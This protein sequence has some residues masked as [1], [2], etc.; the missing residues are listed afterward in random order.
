MKDTKIFLEN[1]GGKNSV[2]NSGGLNVSLK[3]NRKLIPFNDMGEVISSLDVYNDE[4]RECNKIRLTCQVNPICSNVLFNQISEIVKYEG[5]EDV[6]FVNYAINGERRDPFGENQVVY[7]SEEM[8]FW[9]SDSMNYLSFDERLA[10]KSIKTEIKDIIQEFRNQA[11]EANG[12]VEAG[13]QHPTNAIRDTQLSRNDDNGEHFVYHCGLDFLNN[14]LIRSKTFKCICKMPKESGYDGFNTIADYMR[15]V[16]GNEVIEK[17]Y[18]PISAGVNGHTKL[19]VLHT[20]LYDDILTFEE[21][22]NKKLIKTYNGWLGFY[23]TS[24]IKSYEDFS[25]DKDLRIERPLMYLNG[26]DFVDMYPGRDLYSFVPKFNHYRQRIEKNWNYCLTYP[27]SS[28]TEG[29]DDIIERND[30]IN[31]LKTI[32]FDETRRS[33]NGTKM[34]AM[35][36]KAKHGLNQGDYVNIYRTYVTDL[37]WVS[38]N[39]NRVSDMFETEEE[40][41]NEKKLLEIS[42]PTKEY[43]IETVQNQTVN[44]KII[45]NAEVDNIVDDFIF[46]VFSQGIEISRK[47]VLLT[48]E[49]LNSDTLTVDGGDTYYI[50]TGR[51]FY[52]LPDNPD[53][54]YYIVGEGEE[55]YVNFD[56]N[57][58]RISYK[59]VVNDIECEYY[60]R[61]F[62]R[63]PNFKYSSGDTSNEY[64]IYRPREDKTD[65]R[66]LIDIYQQQEFDFESHVSRLAFARNIYR[67]EVGEIVFTDDIDL[68]FIKD[69]LGRPLSEIFITIVKNN[70][71]YK[72]WYGFNRDIDINDST[73]EYSHCFG[74]ITCG[75]EM[76]YES[77]FDDNANNIKRIN[78][79]AGLTTGYNIDMLNGDAHRTYLDGSNN[80]VDIDIDEIWF[81]ND[82]K[83]YGDLCYYDNYNAIERSI[84]PILHRFNTAQR[85]SSVSRYP[86]NFTTFVYDEISKDDYDTDNYFRIDSNKRTQ[87]NSYKEGY[88]YIPHYQIPIKS[89]GVVKTVMPDFLRIRSLVNDSSGATIT[90]LENHFLSPGDKSIIYDTST[91]KYYYC[92]TTTGT[93]DNPKVFTCMICDEDGNPT[94]EVDGN[95]L[96]NEDGTTRYKL[97][98][99]DN[100]DIPSYARVLKDGTCRLIWRDL[101]N[102]GFNTADKT[103][104]EYPFTNGA[105]YVNRR[106]DMFVRRQDPLNLYGLYSQDDIEGIEAPIEGENNYI[107]EQ[108]IEC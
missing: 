108:N 68:S 64:E 33:D 20:Y 85:E 9:S 74:K 83:Y 31:S 30:G 3:G 47:W 17:L 95:H 34:L 55:R 63:L 80:A 19:L 7:K 28:T 86:N 60:V 75:F 4:R 73:V 102:N 45:D 15:D 42:N 35:Y 37:F 13:S 103:L 105:F 57:A 92:T 14:H 96:T 77:I 91:N 52:Y 10:S 106:I 36:S 51:K 2:S 38:H 46:T 25:E 81:D 8:D 11:P 50:D 94:R 1:F 21:S 90:T 59:K 87:L 39:G 61:I 6:T 41:I 89:Y 76:S 98:K 62:S 104:E 88:Y 66:N 49:D 58:Q 40:A 22:V 23:N 100:L 65:T 5:S 67:D 12:N 44:R 70:K 79:I 26:G 56:D 97:F 72:E 84:Q 24:K 53:V 69:N 101:L 78:N 27:S 82:T 107:R 71:G 32:Y 29:F 99:M 18:F 16:S 93:T 54:R 43:D 48:E